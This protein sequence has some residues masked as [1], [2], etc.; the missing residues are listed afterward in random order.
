MKLS[1]CAGCPDWLAGLLA[2]WL[3]CAETTN[4]LNKDGMTLMGPINSMNSVWKKRTR[5][6]S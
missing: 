4:K 5:E 3:N 1:D 6:A 2:G